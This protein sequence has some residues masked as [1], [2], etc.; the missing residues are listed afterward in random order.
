MCV[1]ST[2]ASSCE[3][4]LSFFDVMHAAPTQLNYISLGSHTTCVRARTRAKI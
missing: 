3:K 2:T 4:N 1:C